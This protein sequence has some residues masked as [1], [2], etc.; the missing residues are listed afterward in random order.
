MTLGSSPEYLKY[1]PRPRTECPRGMACFLIFRIFAI[2]YRKSYL[3]RVTPKLA[4]NAAKRPHQQ[5]RGRRVSRGANP[6]FLRAFLQPWR[7]TFCASL[8]LGKRFLPE[9]KDTAESTRGAKIHHHNMY[10]MH[11]GD[12]PRASWLLL[13]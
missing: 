8:R 1:H 10:S 6:L 9:S 2:F 11:H 3:P 5:N 13:L 4:Q 12:T 7:A